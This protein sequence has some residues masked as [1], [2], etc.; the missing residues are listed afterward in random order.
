[1]WILN[2]IDRL[3]ASA[4]ESGSG[5]R[6]VDILGLGLD[7]VSGTPDIARN[8]AVRVGGSPATSQHGVRYSDLGVVTPYDVEVD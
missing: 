6:D 3:L 2:L 8:D 4:V 7:P 5:S 1:M